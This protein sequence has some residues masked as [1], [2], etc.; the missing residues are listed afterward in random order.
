MVINCICCQYSP[1]WKKNKSL[2]FCGLSTSG[3]TKNCRQDKQTVC[4][5]CLLSIC[6]L[7]QSC[8][9]LC[10]AILVFPAAH[11]YFTFSPH[12]P[13]FNLTNCFLCP[14]CWTYVFIQPYCLDRFKAYSVIFKPK[15]WDE[16]E[17][18]NQRLSTE[19]MLLKLKMLSNNF[20]GLIYL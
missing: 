18:Q 16:A 2:H 20:I 10:T 3:K 4:L 1:V 11:S 8:F 9:L 5:S 15:G 12:Y 7:G 17:R 6:L 19:E 13:F 14:T